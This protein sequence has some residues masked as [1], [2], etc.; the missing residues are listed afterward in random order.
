[1]VGTMAQQESLFESSGDSSLSD[2]VDWIESLLLGEVA[3]ALSV[4]AVAMIGFIMLTGRMPFRE[5]GRMALGIFILLGAPAIAAAFHSA[6]EDNE[7][8]APIASATVPPEPVRDL[9]PASYDPYAGA[10]L[11]RD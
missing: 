1:M 7:A 9:P 10:S 8:P 4:I 3:I 5:G 6:W 11:R 2:S